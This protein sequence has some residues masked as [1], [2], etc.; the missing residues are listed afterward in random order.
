[1][2]TAEEAGIDMQ[3]RSVPDREL[4]ALLLG[5]RHLAIALVDKHLLG[6]GMPL[7]SDSR[8]PVTGA[9]Y[10]GAPCFAGWHAQLLSGL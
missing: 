9:G 2:Q 1:M 8:S 6:L 10:T 7:W 5:G 4:Q 3:Q